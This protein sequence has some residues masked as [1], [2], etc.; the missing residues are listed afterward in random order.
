MTYSETLRMVKQHTA[1][2]AAVL[3]FGTVTRTLRAAAKPLAGIPA[4]VS[5]AFAMAYVDPFQSG[6]RPRDED[7]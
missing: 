6:R 4:A 3:A 5:R 2:A 1:A 7:Y